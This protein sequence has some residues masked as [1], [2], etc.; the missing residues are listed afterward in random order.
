[1]PDQSASIDT[2]TRISSDMRTT[3]ARAACDAASQASASGPHTLSGRSRA[4][5]ATATMVPMA[6]RNAAGT[7][8][9]GSGTSSAT[10]ARR[11]FGSWSRTADSAASSIR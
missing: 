9:P 2:T 11:A 8:S 10:A 7:S 5:S 1:M 4:S 6:A 3:A